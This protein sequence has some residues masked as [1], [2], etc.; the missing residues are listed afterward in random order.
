MLTKITEIFLAK[1]IIFGNL[2]KYQD[3]ERKIIR[4]YRVKFFSRLIY[5]IIIF[6]AI[7]ALLMALFHTMPFILIST[8]IGLTI[9][10]VISANNKLQSECE[11]NV[12]FYRKEKGMDEL[13]V[14]TSRGTDDIGAVKIE[15]DKKHALTESRIL[16][17]NSNI[18]KPT[19][20]IS[21]LSSR[22]AVEQNLQQKTEK[23][24]NLDFLD[25]TRVSKRSKMHY[26]NISE[27]NEKYLASSDRFLE[28]YM[29]GEVDHLNTAAK[30][31]N[32]RT[33]ATDKRTDVEVESNNV[34]SQI[35]REAS[36]SQTTAVH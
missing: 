15:N 27:E 11:K 12:D 6:S 31:E 25:D 23:G 21:A 24:F 5:R 26:S 3:D 29:Q 1:N 35:R 14:K 4:S 22:S 36:N 30:V 9:W 10:S 18:R 32:S 7:L 28:E 16:R 34:N 19:A 33:I 17:N 2:D 8:L 13:D 20:K